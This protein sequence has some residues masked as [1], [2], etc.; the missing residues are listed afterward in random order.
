MVYYQKKIIMHKLQRIYKSNQEIGLCNLRLK[1]FH[2]YLQFYNFSSFF[3]LNLVSIFILFFKTAKN[4]SSK[5]F[6]FGLWL[7][8]VLWVA[9]RD[10][11]TILLALGWPICLNS[12][13]GAPSGINYF[14]T[15]CSVVCRRIGD[16]GPRISDND[17]GTKWLSKA[18]PH[19]LAAWAFTF[20]PD[21][22]VCR[23]LLRLSSGG[24]L[25]F[26]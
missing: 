18:L 2:H 5:I 7:L 14:L 8:I 17:L 26:Y 6:L 16:G 10:G 22:L 3:F 23:I 11:I 25:I 15:G 24:T 19:F 20:A 9:F 4:W 21:P 1:Y 12:H 13:G